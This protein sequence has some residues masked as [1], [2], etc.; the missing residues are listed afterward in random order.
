MLDSGVAPPSYI[1]VTQTGVN[2]R[3]PRHFHTTRD[4]TPLPFKGR[5][6]YEYKVVLAHCLAVLP[7]WREVTLEHLARQ[8]LIEVAVPLDD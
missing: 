3:F 1:S 6:A 7:E 4:W 2:P 8:T 5:P